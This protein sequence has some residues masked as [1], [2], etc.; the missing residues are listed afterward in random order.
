MMSHVK[1]SM[2]SDVV[3]YFLPTTIHTEFSKL[4]LLPGTPLYIHQTKPFPPQI[5]QKPKKLFP[6]KIFTMNV[7]NME[8]IKSLF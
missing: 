2:N 4:P 7:S 5:S 8:N 3:N 6:F 1:W